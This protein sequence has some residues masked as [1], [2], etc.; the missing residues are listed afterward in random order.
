MATSIGLLILGIVV[1]LVVGGLVGTR[2]LLSRRA[3]AAEAKSERATT[4]AVRA[5]E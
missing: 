4:D 5:A 2:V 3:A 1:G